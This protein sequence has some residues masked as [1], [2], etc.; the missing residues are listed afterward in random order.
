MRRG[1][2]GGV[3]WRGKKRNMTEPG[4]LSSRMCRKRLSHHLLFCLFSMEKEKHLKEKEKK[5]G[6]RERFVVEASRSGCELP[7][8]VKL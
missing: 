7:L 8:S 5:E 2:G 1:G 4:A 6:G 3:E